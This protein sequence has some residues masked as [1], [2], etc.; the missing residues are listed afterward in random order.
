MNSVTRKLEVASN[1]AI[2]TL[3]IVISILGVKRF[4]FADTANAR[5][6]Q[7][8][9]PGFTVSVPGIDWRRNGQSLVLAFSPSCH[10]C[11]ESAPFYQRLVKETTTDPTIRLVGVFP[12]SADD[13]EA[14]LRNLGVSF[15]TVIKGSF[16]KLGVSGTPT[17]LL[18]NQDGVVSHVWIGKLNPDKER[19]V[20]QQIKPGTMTS[21]YE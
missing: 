3:A 7:R 18:V 21:Q 6:A 8:A 15:P 16:D 17:L 13:G 10:F 20:L 2:I 1:L 5:N 12:E 11:T 4:F 9:K 14:Y 19:E